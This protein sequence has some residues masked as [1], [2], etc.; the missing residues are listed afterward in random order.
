L[1][2]NSTTSSKPVTLDPGNYRLA[3]KARSIPET[4]VNNENAH[5]TLSLS[6]KKIGAYFLTEK[7]EEINYFQFD[8]VKK[9]EYKVELTFDNDFV[10][11]NADRIAPQPSSHPEPP[12]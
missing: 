5:L 10:L 11:N 4:P 1:F 8:V 12:N 9:Q 7:A 3:I 2:S 6:G